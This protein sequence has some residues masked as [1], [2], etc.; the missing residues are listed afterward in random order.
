MGELVAPPVVLRAAIV[1]LDGDRV[2][3]VIEY[4]DV[5]G[6]P[7]PPDAAVTDHG[8][9]HVGLI[10]DDIDATRADLEAR[11]ATFLTKEVADLRTVA[12]VRTTWFADPWGNV[13]ILVEKRD[14]NRPYWSQMP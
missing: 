4:P 10:C 1:G 3:E 8:F 5:V 6:R 12:G 14:P 2:L 9:T 11:G 7:R 13:F